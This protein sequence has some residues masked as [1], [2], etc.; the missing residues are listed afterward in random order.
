MSTVN[1]D[2]YI[3]IPTTDNSSDAQYLVSNFKLNEGYNLGWVSDAEVTLISQTTTLTAGSVLGAVISTGLRPGVFVVLSLTPNIADPSSR[4][5]PCM[6][7][8]IDPFV[9]TTDQLS[10]GCNLRLVDP[11]T[12]LAD[13]TIWGAYR[14]CSVGEMIGGA[15]SMA[16]GGDGEPTL[17]PSLAGLTT[18]NITES[19]R[20]YLK[21]LPYSIAVG[22]TLGRWL[23]DILN[24]LGLRV[25]ML[26][27]SDDNSITLTLSDRTP[28]GGNVL[29]MTTLDNP[30][31]TPGPAGNIQIIGF[32]G[33]P[34]VKRRATSLD[35]L[36]NTRRSFGTL[37][38]IH[39]TISGP[40][41]SIDEAAH[42]V[43][44]TLRGVYASMLQMETASFQP[45]LRPGRLVDLTN[46]V[47]SIN[48][49]SWQITDVSHAYENN[50][51]Y[52][53]RATMIRGD[54]SW[55]PAPPPTRAP[56][57]VSGIIDD[58]HEY[59]ESNPVPRDHFG[60]IVV[61]FPFSP[62][63]T[64]LDRFTAR[65][66]DKNEDGRTTIEDFSEAQV[67]DYSANAERWDQELQNLENGSYDRTLEEYNEYQEIINRA[68]NRAIEDKKNE[69]NQ[70]W[71][72]REREWEASD[73]RTAADVQLDADIAELRNSDSESFE[74]TGALNRAIEARKNEHLQYWRERN[75]EA[76]EART[77]S[78]V[79]LG[80]DIAEL[81]AS[82]DG[83]I[84]VAEEDRARYD[85]IRGK[86]NKKEAAAEYRGYK[87]TKEFDGDRNN[88]RDGLVNASDPIV[89][90]GL[91]DALQDGTQ[92]DVLQKQWEKMKAEKQQGV[93]YD[94]MLEN[95][96]NE[97]SGS[98]SWLE[99]AK[100]YGTLYDAEYDDI[101]GDAT[102]QQMEA[103]EK[104]EAELQR[105]PPRIPLS[106]IE[107]MAGG[108][109]GFIPS[110]RQ[111]DVC[112]V[113]VYSPLWAE[114]VGFQYRGNQPINQTVIDA[115]A[116]LVVEHDKGENWSGM[117]FKRIELSQ[118]WE[119]EQN[120]LSTFD[121]KTQEDVINREKE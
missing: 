99:L 97:D 39:R 91:R 116:G 74:N 82:E 110:H 112:R 45:G 7:E 55:H 50:K 37:G 101:F 70:Y 15:L 117:V 46:L 25:E 47:S 76:S 62:T 77:A 10:G 8:Q 56:V 79:Q 72:E 94:T 30:T 95:E 86:M 58:G 24:E 85:E 90:A 21:Y 51:T 6:I 121:F 65:T 43:N 107:P 84:R 44:D 61:R 115:T 36:V 33:H 106:V 31:S 67:D 102:L 81:K 40:D 96:E 35:A 104:A 17:N 23:G 11:V 3:T 66:T 12:Y 73:E 105:W 1:Y 57:L 111:G 75:F 108:G 63:P 88:D 26:G 119:V 60:R 113:A 41:V 4:V 59:A 52:L 69:Y 34:G 38:G 54:T 19:Y 32:S 2:S 5:W 118:E 29:S 14:A 92:R 120:F 114:I 103:K 109:H 22:Q 71:M 80:A 20:D 49:Q 98:E 16:V 9:S 93:T 78:E 68:L 28:S 13:R 64:Y 18:I 48:V 87:Q 89:S 53:N 83:R 100:E 27:N 42:R